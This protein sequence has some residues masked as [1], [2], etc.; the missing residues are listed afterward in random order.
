MNEGK[1]DKEV[2]MS[3]ASMAPNQSDEKL[4]VVKEIVDKCEPAPEPDSCEY[5]FKFM[6]CMQSEA[7]ARNITSD[8]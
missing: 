2:F 5:V 7:K 1:L 3:M 4:A 8:M 6:S